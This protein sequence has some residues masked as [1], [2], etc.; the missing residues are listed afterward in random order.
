M[1]IAKGS[2]CNMHGPWY[3]PRLWKHLLVGGVKQVWSSS[4]GKPWSY[5]IVDE[6]PTYGENTTYA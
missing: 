3:P 2:T 4:Y 5:E 6:W 1:M